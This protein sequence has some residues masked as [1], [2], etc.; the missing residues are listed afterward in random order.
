MSIA[1]ALQKPLIVM[2]YGYPGSGKTYF[3][4]QLSEFVSM[5]HL[6]ADRIRHELFER[7]RHDKE[8]DGIVNHLMDYMCEE[9]LKSGVSVVYDTG[10]VR[11]S[12]RR[13]LRDTARRLK[14]NHVLIWLQI[15][16]QSALERTTGRNKRKTDDKYAVELNQN[17]FDAYVRVMQNPTHEDYFVI[18]GK[19]TFDT[20][21]SAVIKK[22]YDMGFVDSNMAQSRLVKP[23]LV[24][25]VPPLRQ[26]RVDNTRRNIFIR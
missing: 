5:A 6:Q 15:D 11:I 9:F 1:P 23:E 10:A 22:L 14:A 24:S 16:K 25:L 17:E 8:E 3:A 18:S 4:R 20:Q 7:P 19:H 12:Q 21:R 13:A 26:G 2:L